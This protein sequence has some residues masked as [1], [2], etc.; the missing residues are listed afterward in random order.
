MRVRFDI[1]EHSKVWDV[2][3]GVLGLERDC[4]LTDD[5]IEIDEEDFCTIKIMLPD[6]EFESF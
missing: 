6:V 3:V 5:C 2:L 1:K 4:F